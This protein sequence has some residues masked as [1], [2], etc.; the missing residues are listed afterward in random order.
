MNHEIIDIILNLNKYSKTEIFE[1]DKNEE[2]NETNFE[3]IKKILNDRLYRLLFLKHFEENKE[4]FNKAKYYYLEKILKYA[5]LELQ[6]SSTINEIFEILKKYIIYIRE[7]GKYDIKKIINN[8]LYKELKEIVSLL[9]INYNI[10]KEIS[11]KQYDVKYKLIE[12]NIIINEQGYN[13][14]KDET[15]KK[16]IQKYLEKLN[17]KILKNKVLTEKELRE[18][19]ILSSE[20]NELIEKKNIDYIIK[21][22]IK[23]KVECEEDIFYSLFMKNICTY[24]IKKLDLISITIL[25]KLPNSLGEAISGNIN[26]V[27]LDKESLIPKNIVKNIETIFHEIWH[28]I[29]DNKLEYSYNSQKMV[30]D[31]ILVDYLGK[32]FDEK[33]YW[34]L[35]YEIDARFNSEYI[36]HMY[37][38]RI[39]KE[40]ARIYQEKHRTGY[41]NG[42]E[43][44]YND[45][46]LCLDV[47]FDEKV[48]ALKIERYI[49]SNEIYGKYLAL[50]YNKNGTKKSIATL[51]KEK[52]KL[53]QD[54][55]NE[56]KIK[57]L[58]EIIYK[59]DYKVK[60]YIYNVYYCLYEEKVSIEEFERLLDARM[61]DKI[62][63]W[64]R[65]D[66]EEEQIKKFITKLKNIEFLEI[67]LSHE[68]NLIQKYKI[69]INAM[70][71][72]EYNL[73]MQTKNYSIVR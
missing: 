44:I 43:R 70:G 24:Y 7:Y 18:Y 71:K 9:G 20:F 31:Q 37:L 50:E 23:N 51:I 28:I 3:D 56:D 36:T 38:K 62:L 33:N 30:K 2:I 6:K 12:E 60:D 39:S 47:I 21:Q 32:E 16:Y 29:Q 40:T 69:F 53:K 27:K 10:Y 11:E 66:E 72:I 17:K 5:T 58:E 8:P 34:Q 64:T 41:V 54:R 67:I 13:L 25:T 65:Y 52:N 4:T 63:L 49:Q 35:S 22:I 59:R 42:N 61:I 45:K 15:I 14:E 68:K 55:V 26:I 48:S 1:C 46:T 73:R 19:M 57:V